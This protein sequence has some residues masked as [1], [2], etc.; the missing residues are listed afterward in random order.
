M[1]LLPH[2]RCAN[3]TIRLF[4]TGPPLDHQHFPGLLPWKLFTPPPKSFNLLLQYW[5]AADWLVSRTVGGHP[6][7]WRVDGNLRLTR[8]SVSINFF[9]I[10]YVS[11]P[12]RVL[13]IDFTSCNI[14]QLSK[15]YVFFAYTNKII[16]MGSSV[17]GYN[18]LILYTYIIFGW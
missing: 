1:Y 15:V 9:F 4:S 8:S 7:V 10:V 17:G 6:C 5:D 13:Y 16:W 3:C 18:F 2:W 14:Q 12:R 11:P